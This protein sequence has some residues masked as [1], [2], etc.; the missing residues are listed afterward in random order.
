MSEIAELASVH[1]HSLGAANAQGLARVGVV[2]ALR[3]VE[4]SV[5]ALETLAEQS[6]LVSRRTQIAGPVSDL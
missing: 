2:G 1:Q 5:A 3:T 4:G 6:G